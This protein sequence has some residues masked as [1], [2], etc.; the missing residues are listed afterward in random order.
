MASS[1][2]LFD[3]FPCMAA[4]SKQDPSAIIECSYLV[5]GLSADH[6]RRLLASCVGLIE[7]QMETVNRAPTGAGK[8]FVPLSVEF[9]GK[10]VAIQGG[11]HMVGAVHGCMEDKYD[12]YFSQKICILGP[13]D[14][15]EV[16]ET[17]E[18]YLA[19]FFPVQRI[20]YINVEFA[21][22][23]KYL[24]VPPGVKSK[25]VV[26]CIDDLSEDQMKEKVASLFKVVSRCVWACACY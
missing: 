1:S 15:T 26:E 11:A 3:D 4:S 5:A 12:T 14:D 7:R 9:D 8:P 6:R 25:L 20:H 13:K 19:D 17:Y 22:V 24:L 16:I 21:D 23:G 18:Q 2:R 10:V